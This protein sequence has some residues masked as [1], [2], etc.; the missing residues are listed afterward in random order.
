MLRAIRSRASIRHSHVMRGRRSRAV[1]GTY[2]GVVLGTA[3]A[4]TDARVSNGVALHLVDG[5]LGSV[6]VD[7]LN[8]TAAL[9]R[10]DLDIG[11]FTKAL[12]EGAELVLSHVAREAADEDGSVVGVSELV[13]LGSWVEASIA[14]VLHVAS[15]HGL[16]RHTTAHHLALVAVTEAAVVTAEVRVSF[17]RHTHGWHPW[18][19]V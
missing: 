7:E 9:A 2:A 5:H 14:E 10:R 16:L 6:A 4:E 11:D 1:R 12:E 3:P 17:A 8:E 15:P 19:A 18:I 13:H